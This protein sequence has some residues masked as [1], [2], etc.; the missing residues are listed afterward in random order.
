MH[1]QKTKFSNRVNRVATAL[2]KRGIR[3]TY[4]LHDRV[5]SNR[6]SRRRFSEDHPELDDVQQQSRHRRR[7][8]RI[9]SPSLFRAR[10]RRDMRRPSR[11]RVTAS[12]R[13]PRTRSSGRSEAKGTPS[14]AVERARSSSFARTASRTSSSGSTTPGSQPC[15][16]TPHARSWRAATSGCGR[17]SRTPT[18]GTRSHSR[19]PPRASR[20]SSGTGT[21]TTST[22]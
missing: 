17:S 3:A 13:R 20:R 9:R 11:T 5:L 16:S 10:R 14:F 21:S 15:I 1:R 7:R 4:E 19:R 22:C 2:E 8:A 6:A 18:S 12:P